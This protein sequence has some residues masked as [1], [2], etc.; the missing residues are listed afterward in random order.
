MVD[1]LGLVVA[2][3]VLP[4]D[5]TDWEGAVRLF[6]QA[7]ARCPRLAKVWADSAYRAKELAKW[8][9]AN[10]RWVL[11]V[12]T[13]ADDAKGFVVLPRRWIVERTFGWFGRYRRLSK[14]YETN[15]RSSEA[16]IKVAMI[17]RMS[18]YALPC[19]NRDE[20]LLRRPPH[21]KKTA[22]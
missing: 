15:T 4:A 12:V 8:M 3:V 20:H 1:T 5:V 6:E 22:C 21:R 13:R 18:R 14:D 17:H 2:L 19:Q 9:A 16:W 11:E 10:C 7:K